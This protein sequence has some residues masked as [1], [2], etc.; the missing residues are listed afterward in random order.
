MSLASLG[1]RHMDSQCAA[2]WPGSVICVP[3]REFPQACFSAGLRV[4]SCMDLSDGLVLDLHRLCRESGVSA[5][6][7]GTVPIARGASL[8]DALY[9]GEDYELLFT[10]PPKVKIPPR[11]GD[12]RVTEI[13][14]M[15]A[16]RPGRITFAGHVLQPKG[17]DHFS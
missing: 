17:F 8:E 12:L 7:S 16:G 5:N 1:R 13:G 6:L 9:G 15:A 2:A 14:E 4:S 11:L 10:A 3:T